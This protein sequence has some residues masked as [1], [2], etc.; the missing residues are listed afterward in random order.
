MRMIRLPKN[1]WG[2]RISGH[3]RISTMFSYSQKCFYCGDFIFLT[4]EKRIGDGGLPSKS[5]SV[6]HIYSR[7][8]FRRKYHCKRRE[9]TPIVLSCHECNQN[10][11]NLHF[12]EFCDIMNVDLDG[13]MYFI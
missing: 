3:K 8:D 2:W 6:D 4:C 1:K 9:E 13:S 5:A 10:R 7:T 11:S 12:E